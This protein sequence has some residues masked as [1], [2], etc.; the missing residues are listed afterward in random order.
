[1]RPILFLLLLLFL[2]NA[3]VAQFT[4]KIF[5]DTILITNPDSAELIIENHTQAVPGFL[6]NKGKGR[7]EFRK[8]LT[9]LDASTYMLG[10]DTL[11]VL[12]S[13]GYWQANGIH[14]YNT[15]PGNVGILRPIPNAML[16]LP[17]AVNIDDSSAYRINYH[18][19]LRMGG[20][21][22]SGYTTLF[23][24]DSSG[25]NNAGT[26]TILIGNTT[27]VN[28]SGGSNTFLGYAAG[29]D[30]VGAGN[31]FSG[32]L[33]GRNNSVD[34]SGNPSVNNSF[35]G[36]QSGQNSSGSGNTFLGEA[37]GYDN[38]GSYNIYGGQDAGYESYGSYNCFLSS[39]YPG[40]DNSGSYNILLGQFN[41]YDNNGNNN[42]LI[43]SSVYS[44]QG[45]NNIAMG[46]TAGQINQ[47]NTNIMLGDQAGNV[48]TGNNNII[49]G[50]TA[51]QYNQAD[52]NVFI[53][54]EAGQ[55]NVGGSENTFVGSQAGFDNGDLNP[56]R[57]GGSENTYLGS[58]AG[59][60]TY[61]GD[62][63]T[64]IG[65]NSV[66]FGVAKGSGNTCA[67]AVSA[68]YLGGNVFANENTCLGDS[69]NW[70]GSMGNYNV[71]FGS[72][73]AFQSENYTN[74]G[75]LIGAQANY[76]GD[77]NGDYN[78]FLGSL[79]SVNGEQDGGYNTILGSGAGVECNMRTGVTLVGGQ[80][81]AGY[82]SSDV[83][84]A[85]AIGYNA[86]VNASNTM[87]FGDT[88]T[89]TWLFGIDYLVS[90]IPLFN[91]ALQVGTNA[92]NGNGA[93]LTNGGAWTN[94]SDV[95]KKENFEPL[96]GGEIL[97]R[98]DQLPITRW[99]YKG[100]AGQHIGPVAQDFYR[101]F[102]VGDND[103]TISTID[104]SGIALAGIREL[105]GKYSA[106]LQQTGEQQNI[107][108]EQQSRIEQQQ[109]QIDDLLSQFQRQNSEIAGRQ[110]RIDQLLEKLG[111]LEVALNSRQG[112]PGAIQCKGTSKQIL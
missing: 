22:D 25:A 37:A 103:R 76:Y 77:N 51:G 43:G 10:Q 98:I 94:A 55:L 19:A 105:Y 83:S 15:N 20:I 89:T 35:M 62:R 96:N 70:G 86:V 18:T 39:N 23:A 9:Q 106:T 28:N 72:K 30:N 93:F 29:H 45:D 34:S 21:T 92:T 8:I 111:K 91:A 112:V 63:N 6:F 64:F 78:I 80:S 50:A 16:D 54:Y 5:A 42:L 75:V 53:G 82:Q 11:H 60:Y 74:Y 7:T 32:V 48:N 73:S 87:V 66:E 97:D 24:G 81:N 56:Y 1:M 65:S 4:Y 27:G 110:T 13:S 49:L 46:N 33:S 26:Y 41:G 100:V 90:G 12:G 40:S 79:T 88:L 99:S 85:T 38:Y 59:S 102:H 61:P 2:A 68:A 69:S 44:N 17:G 107:I 3:A 108:S 31:T 71:Y 36:Y 109:E 14:I 47:G 52:S 101:I 84:D 58:R 95:A 104:P 67:G 57:T